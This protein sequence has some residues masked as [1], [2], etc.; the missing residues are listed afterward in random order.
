MALLLYNLMTD[1]YRFFF[2]NSFSVCCLWYSYV[3]VHLKV[4]LF[5]SNLK[6]F[7]TSVVIRLKAHQ[8]L[9]SVPLLSI[10]IW[11]NIQRHILFAQFSKCIKCNSAAFV[12]F[13][14]R[15]DNRPTYCY[16]S[17]SYFEYILWFNGRLLASKYCK[18][19]EN[20]K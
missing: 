13:F 15:I 4:I 2:L 11:Y 8:S 20:K 1:E 5:D 7:E 16:C 14:C 19:S 9:F 3:Y 12:C 18:M 17:I 6:F 10:Y